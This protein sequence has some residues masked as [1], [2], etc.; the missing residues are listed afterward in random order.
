MESSLFVWAR[1]MR[2]QEHPAKR[3]SLAKKRQWLVF[4]CSVAALKIAQKDSIRFVS[5]S[6]AH[7]GGA[8]LVFTKTRSF[9]S[10][11]SQWG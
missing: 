5:K 10:K 11:E 7:A 4:F 8:I 9:E 2:Q 6:G 1:K 3:V